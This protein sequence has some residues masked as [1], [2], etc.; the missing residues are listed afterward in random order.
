[1]VALGEY[2]YAWYLH[3]A[4]RYR[5]FTS[6][7]PHHQSQEHTFNMPRRPPPTPLRLHQGPMPSR[8]KPKHTMPSLP[9]PVFHLPIPVVTGFAPRPRARS[10][11]KHDEPALNLQTMTPDQLP[12]L[13]FPS[14]LS[15]DSRRSSTDSGA[16]SPV[17]VS[18]RES[19]SSPPSPASEHFVRGPW[20]H[21]ASIRVSI[22]IS[23]VLP[24]PRPAALFA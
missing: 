21:S 19:D 8:G 23:A 12:N 4:L 2:I 17:S 14:R 3:Q 6:Y 13:A 18:S 22:D 15:L 1:M 16:S 10:V 7:T 9:R 5:L 24:P 20:D 11:A